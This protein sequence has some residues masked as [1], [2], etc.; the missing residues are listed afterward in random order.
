MS[1]DTI[2]V[3]MSGRS[4]ALPPGIDTATQAFLT[5]LTK[6]NTIRDR[7]LVAVRDFWEGGEAAISDRYFPRP[8]GCEV[9]DWIQFRRLLTLVNLVRPS[10]RCWTAAVY[11]GQVN[12]VI[13]QNPYRPCIDSWVHSVEYGEAIQAWMEN[14]VLYGT[15]VAIPTWDPDTDEL[16]VWLPCPLH[17]YVFTDPLNVRKVQGVAEVTKE[18]ITYWSVWGN[19]YMTRT[20]S[21]HT[22]SSIGWLPVAIAYGSDRRHSG[23][24]YGISLV[25]DAV[26]WS[27][28]ATDISFNLAILQKLQT[29]AYLVLIGNPEL[30]A[31][32]TDSWGPDKAL[33]M[34]I[35]A[36]AK[37]ITPDAKI[38]ETIDIL[39]NVLG[40][41]ATSSSIP[42]DVLDSTLTVQVGS[43]ESARIRALPLLQRA[44]QLVPVWSSNETNLILA[45]TGLL[46]YQATQ[47]PIGIKDLRA[48]TVTDVQIVPNILPV[49][50][51]ELTQDIIARLT[52]GLITPE[53]AVRQ[54]YPN[55]PDAAVAAMAARILELQDDKGSA[56]VGDAAVKGAAAA[57]SEVPES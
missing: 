55:K 15:S 56:E 20:A 6:L 30:S 16:G 29:R 17:T 52:V 24:P 8:E 46:E 28:R 54:L 11:G 57:A 44:R 37:F 22:P 14:A 4:F 47:A 40:L 23:E 12:R 36:D 27:Q 26:A 39:K 2:D 43:A 3:P 38:K 13:S 50:P 32:K 25:R 33:K 41:L 48:R 9:R 18:R 31:D 35:G 42:N 19:G 5:R 51:N 34:D 7:E 45:M 10:V 1:N 21:E 53:D 49:S